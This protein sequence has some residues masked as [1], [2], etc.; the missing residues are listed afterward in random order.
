MDDD[1]F[2]SMNPIAVPRKK[3][4]YIKKDYV[5]SLQVIY[6]WKNFLFVVMTLCFMVLQM[7]FLLVHYGYIVPGENIEAPRS[8]IRAEKHPADF[9]EIGLE[10]EPKASEHSGSDIKFEHVTLVINITNTILIFSSLLYSFIMFY[11]LGASLGGHLGGLVHISRACVYSLII[12]ILLLPWQFVFK[13]V[14]LGAV[15]TPRELSMW[16]VANITE[17]PGKVLLYLRFTGYSILVFILLILAQ[18]QSL[19]WSR[20]VTRKLE[21]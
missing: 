17:M 13:Y 7:S 9:T 11:G 4:L 6:R 1:L 8:F 16:H 19:L 21:R 12:L 20:A 10:K 5:R 15:Y 3:D 2:D 18:L 14:V